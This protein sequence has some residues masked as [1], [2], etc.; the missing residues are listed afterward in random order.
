MQVLREAF[1]DGHLDDEFVDDGSGGFG[2]LDPWTATDTCALMPTPTCAKTLFR[3]QLPAQIYI[4]FSFLYS[5]AGCP[6]CVC[7][8]TAVCF[9]GW[10]SLV[11]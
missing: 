10:E 5:S 1:K 3:L 2:D 7:G 4:C 6:D 8:G 9:G 11:L